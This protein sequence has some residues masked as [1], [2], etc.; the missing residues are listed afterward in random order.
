V[1]T[2]GWVEGRGVGLITVSEGEA[3]GVMT[4]V[5]NGATGTIEKESGL[6]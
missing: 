3:A 1:I 2:T 6:G 4:K 5:D